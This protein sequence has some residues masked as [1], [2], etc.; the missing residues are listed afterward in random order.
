MI[1]AR[2]I[3]IFNACMDISPPC[4]NG[5]NNVIT[6]PSINAHIKV[7][8]IIKVGLPGEILVDA[9][10]EIKNITTYVSV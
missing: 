5:C 4:N 10:R 1:N 7:K 6:V 8:I 3:H 2:G 9:S